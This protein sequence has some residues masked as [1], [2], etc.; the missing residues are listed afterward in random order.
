[1]AQ[2][3]FTRKISA[4]RMLLLVALAVGLMVVDEHTSWLNPARTWLESLGHGLI[5]VVGVTG[6]IGDWTQTHL[7]APG[8]LATENEQLRAEVLVLRGQLQQLAALSAENTQLRALLNAAPRPGQR[9]LLAEL[10]SVSANPSRHQIQ[11]DRG[12][13]DGV[14][15][16]QAVLDANG[17]MGQVIGVGKRRATVLLISDERHALPVSV[18]GSEVRTIAEGTGDYRRL[19]LRHVPPTLDLAVKDRLVTSGAGNRFPPG[20]AVGQVISISQQRGQAFLEV[21]VEPAARLDRSRQLL[22]VFPDPS[23]APPEAVDVRREPT[24]VQE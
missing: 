18:V 14:F 6:R 19:R 4:P 20:Y 24:E 23:A 1:M 10:I 9:L 8:A 22:L 12:T 17:L 13:E 3:I 21:V 7:V 16:G 2:R 15:L 11:I 5:G